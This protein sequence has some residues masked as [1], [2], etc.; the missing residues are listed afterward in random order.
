MQSSDGPTTSL[1]D[2]LPNDTHVNNHSAEVYKNHW[3]CTYHL[4]ASKRISLY[5]PAVFESYVL[6]VHERMT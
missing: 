3:F 2:T 6:I 1:E 5:I 4:P